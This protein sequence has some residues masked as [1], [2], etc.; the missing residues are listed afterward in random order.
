MSYP[1]KKILDLYSRYAINRNN[2]IA[3]LIAK[4]ISDDDNE[5]KILE[6]GAGRG[7]FIDRFSGRENII[8]HV[9]EN[10]EEYF[11]DL[12]LR[13]RA[14]Q[15][16]DEVDHDYDLIFLID[17]LE[18]LE[19]DK[20]FLRKFYSKL[21]SGGRLFIY[22]PARQELFS[23]FDRSIGHFRRYGKS[24]LMAKVEQAE[25]MIEKC[26]YHELAGYFATAVHNV[27]LGK[28]EPKPGSLRIYDKILPFTN[29]IESILPVPIGKSLYLNA[30]RPLG[31]NNRTD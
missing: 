23:D 2:Y 31:G 19:D 21:K 12:S 3:K 24:E 20:M 26:R 29:S 28:K 14:F 11:K 4:N 7:E 30:K 15:S 8:T 10:D 18:H 16:I 22:V 13:H 9:V 6:F 27:F 1:G 17:V 25:F 5:K